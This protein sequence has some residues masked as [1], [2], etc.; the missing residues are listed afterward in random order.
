MLSNSREEVLKKTVELFLMKCFFRNVLLRKILVVIL[1]F[2]W[3]I[4][5]RVHKKI[6][7]LS[8][9]LS[10]EKIIAF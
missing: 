9:I 8:A 7:P 4:N 10:N 5:K 2:S 6:L 3:K 1:E